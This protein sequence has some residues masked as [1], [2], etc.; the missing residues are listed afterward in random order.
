MYAS[1]NKLDNLIATI[2]YNGRQIDG[3]TKDVIS[4]GNL[5]AKFDSNLNLFSISGPAK[6]EYQKEINI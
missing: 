5:E 3:D 2:D 6:I 4:L 1:G